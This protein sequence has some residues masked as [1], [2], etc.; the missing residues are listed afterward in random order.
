MFWKIKEKWIFLIICLVVVF[1]M[2]GRTLWG[3]FVF[4]D[5]GIVEHQ[6]VL[7]FSKLPLVLAM[8]YFTQETGLYRP[9]VLL[10]YAL[11]F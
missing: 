9:T 7:N 6:N 11:N 1:L 4:D 3:D 2:Y 5:R 10:S 8:P